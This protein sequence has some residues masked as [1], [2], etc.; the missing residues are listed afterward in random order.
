MCFVPSARDARCSDF[1]NEEKI[2]PKTIELVELHVYLY[3]DEPR[4]RV[5]DLDQA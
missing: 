4:M 2:L 5:V 3:A 1:E